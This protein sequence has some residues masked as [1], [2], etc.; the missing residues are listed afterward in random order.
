MKKVIICK[1]LPA[2]GKTTWAKTMVSSPPQGSYKRVN[3]DDLRAMLDNSI[4][5]SKNEKYILELR[6]KII[7]DS[8]DS[9]KHVIIDDTN[10]APK[11]EKE[12]KELVDQ[13]NKD[14]NDD[15]SIEIKF[16][17]ISIEE[18]IKRD[19][20]RPNS[21]GSGVILKMYNDFLKPRTKD[22]PTFKLTQ[23]PELPYTIV[24]DIDGTL[25]IRRDRGPFDWE[26][27][28]TD[29]PNQI[30]CN[31]L[32]TLYDEDISRS[33]IF[34]SGRKNCCREKTEAWLKKYIG[35]WTE[36]CL[37]FMRGDDDNRPDEILKKE[38]FVKNI[39][40]KF[41]VEFVLDDRNKTVKGWR[42][43]G[44]TCLQVAEGDF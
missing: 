13:Y 10:L 3:K 32:K 25:A 30:I 7:I 33:I 35:D 15:V 14:H 19:L 26:K 23:N 29:L 39:Y 27:V 20:A 44:L 41:Y 34:V 2:S 38:I 5:S 40:D 8:L 43:L 6:N 21:V 16:F 9:G 36:N 28:N 1:G 37:L 24:C 22:E 11:H 42:E 17:E 12:I 4:W 18:A 31:L